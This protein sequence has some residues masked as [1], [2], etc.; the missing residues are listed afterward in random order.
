M[1]QTLQRQELRPFLPSRYR[2]NVLLRRQVPLAK[3]VVAAVVAKAKAGPAIAHDMEPP[4]KKRRQL[5][6][7]KSDEVIDRALS[8]H[9]GHMTKAKLET[10]RINGLLLRERLE[11]DSAS[12][13][14]SGK[15]Q[16]FGTC[17]WRDLAREWAEGGDVAERL[18]LKNRGGSIRE[19]LINAIEAATLPSPVMRSTEALE[20]L[21]EHTE[22]LSDREWAELPCMAATSPA[23]GRD[24]QDAVLM[25]M[26]KHLVRVRGEVTYPREWQVMSGLY[27]GAVTRHFHRLCK[28]RVR[29]RTWLRNHRDLCC[30]FM[31]EA[32]V[33]SCLATEDWSLV[34]AEVGRLVA[35]SRIGQAVFGYATNLVSPHSYAGAI[36]DLVS[37]LFAEEVTEQCILAFKQEAES[38]AVELRNDGKLWE[39]REVRV[40]FLGSTITIVLQDPSLELDLQ[41]A[42]RLKSE[43]LLW[44]DGLQ[45]LPYED[46]ILPAQRDGCKLPPKVLESMASARA[47]ASEILQEPGIAGIQEMRK[48]VTS[49]AKALTAIDSSWKL[50][51]EF[52]QNAAEEKLDET[53]AAHLLGS[54]PT[55]QAGVSLAAAI[56][57]M[58]TFSAS[59]LLAMAGSTSRGRFAAVEE[60]LLGLQKGVAPAASIMN[61]EEF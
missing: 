32:D 23:M 42:A 58:E 59:S 3:Y 14:K 60:I 27:D 44:R 22:V 29:V 20:T 52:V 25:A 35:S 19:S 16:R 43:A 11:Q 31:N 28:A 7:R 1:L 49:S 36:Q 21:L 57:D 15:V 47:V 54:L 46:Q 48:L 53:F 12:L 26:L 33:D 38:R 50:E 61:G 55:D 8:Q 2:Q 39:K 41:L 6:R 9:F 40:P 34:Q 51:V 13:K 17:Y 37:K 4:Q 10:K 5:N 24:N 56:A 18:D 30:L 45:R